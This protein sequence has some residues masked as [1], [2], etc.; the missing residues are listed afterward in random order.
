MS[1]IQ[2]FEDLVAWQLAREVTREICFI[3]RDGA[4][5]RDY[6]LVD[7]MRRAAVSIMSNIAEGFERESE[8]DRLR[9][10]MIA[11]ASCAE[12]RSQ[13]YIAFDV[14]YLDETAFDILRSKAERIARVIAGLRSTINR[15][16][17]SANGHR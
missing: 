6:G 2:R 17:H 16:L 3:T 5:S 10:Y 14:G 1:G 11:K 9:F 4:F 8:A 15:D 7:Q 12:L 13:L